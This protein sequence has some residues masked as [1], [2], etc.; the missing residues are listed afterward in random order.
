[1]IR[2]LTEGRVTERD[3][4][5]RWARRN[6]GL[7][8]LDLPDAGVT[9]DALV[10][11]AREYVRRNPRS[12]RA[13]PDTGGAFAVKRYRSVKRRSANG[14]WR[15]TKV[16]LAPTNPDFEPIVLAEDDANDVQVVAEF[17]TVL[18]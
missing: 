3:Y 7:V 9:P 11:Q 6:R 8:R 1:M 12:R 4:L 14:D 16:T 2:V 17:V 18:R 10:R 15:H 5:R 13:D